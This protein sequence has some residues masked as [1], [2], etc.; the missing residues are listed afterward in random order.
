MLLSVRVF[1]FGS[2]PCGVMRLFSVEL[3]IEF[4]VKLCYGLEFLLSDTKEGI[5]LVL[6]SF[7]MK[8]MTLLPKTGVTGL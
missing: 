6:S 7:F 3:D 4:L 2:L 8:I 1:L 5:E